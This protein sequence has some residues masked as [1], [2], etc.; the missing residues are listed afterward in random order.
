MSP[1]DNRFTRYLEA[2]KESLFFG[3]L[4]VDVLRTMLTD[5]K[6]E[7]WDVK[8][9]KNSTEVTFM[10]HFIVRGRIKVF[11]IN[12]I[13]GR[14]HTIFILP[15]GNV[16][17]ILYYLEPVP[18]N[19]YWETLDELELLNIP[20]DKMDYWLD[21]YPILN[22][23]IFLYLAK[24][25]RQFED[26]TADMSLHNTLVR[27]TNLLLKNINGQTNKLEL[28]NNL[29]NDE[30]ANLIGTTRAVVNRH[31]QELKKCGAISVKRKQ[32]DVENIQT[33]LSISEKRFV[34]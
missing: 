2:L 5:M 34:P 3:K 12:P 27:L 31:I 16:F 32:I 6:P 28:I 14:E 20:M 26:T 33:L 21:N 18:H 9:F 15:K 22:K 1:D 17:D 29:P 30:I 11:Q 23:S 19:V 13:T 4:P 24:R 25:M 8:T 10:L 7:I